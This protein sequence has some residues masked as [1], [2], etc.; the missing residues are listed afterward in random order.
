MRL[1]FLDE[2]G[3]IGQDGL[4]ALGGVAVRAATDELDGG[5]IRRFP[6]VPRDRAPHKLF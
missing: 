3:R 6:E 4:V 5:G 2:S 1:P